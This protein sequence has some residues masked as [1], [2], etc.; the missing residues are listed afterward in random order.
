MDVRIGAL[1]AVYTGRRPGMYTSSNGLCVGAGAVPS[2]GWGTRPRSQQILIPQNASEP[3]GSVQSQNLEQG[4]TGGHSPG[5]TLTENE[6]ITL[7]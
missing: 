5:L 4:L 3:V 6:L 2:H 7:F 1:T